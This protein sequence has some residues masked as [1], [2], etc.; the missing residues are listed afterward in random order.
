MATSVEGAGRVDG[1]VG[2]HEDRKAE[3]EVE[4]TEESK[5]AERLRHAATIWGS[6]AL[7]VPDLEEADEQP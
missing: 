4:Q 6:N 2:E 7:A 1:K 3:A 5:A